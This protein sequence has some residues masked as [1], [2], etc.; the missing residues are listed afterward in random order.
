V[1]AGVDDGVLADARDQRVAVMDDLVD[2]V[3][4]G[5]LK[6]AALGANDCLHDLWIALRRPRAT[7]A[8]PPP[9]SPDDLSKIAR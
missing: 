7:G 1:A 9:G 8:F 3:P 2:P 4:L 6:A 5:A